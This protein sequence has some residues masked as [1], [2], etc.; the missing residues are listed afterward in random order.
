VLPQ[1]D[2]PQL[3]G[4]SEVNVLEDSG[5]VSV[6]FQVQDVETP[7]SSLQ[8]FVRSLNPV[9][10]P[11]A[12]ISITGNGAS[13]TIRF[14]PATNLFGDVTLEVAAI[15]LDGGAVTNQVLIK[16]A[17]VND[18]PT[19]APLS[20]VEMDRD[21][22]SAPIAIQIGDVE[23][24]AAALNLSAS[25]STPAL[26]P[27]GSFMFGGAGEQ[28]TL[29]L[30]PAPGQYGTA[31]FTLQVTDLDGGIGERSFQVTV[32][33]VIPPAILVAPT[34]QTVTNGASALF[35]VT[36]GGTLP[37]SYQWTLNGTVLANVGP[38]N[39]G[40]YRVTVTNAGGSVASV[41]ALLRVLVAPQIGSV[42]RSGAGID[43]TFPTLENLSYTV[44]FT[45]AAGPLLWTPLTTV[46][47]SGGVLSVYDPAGGLP[48]RLYRVRVN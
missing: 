3:L 1:N 39:A 31:T 34:G 4:L 14:L 36:A 30:V 44:E 45:E 16:I 8:L 27:A 47:G 43:I 24:P 15:D 19:L 18:L 37:I 38:A 12:S 29:V 23:T 2:L 11:D 25:S 10:V 21:T 13:R 9:F 17:S 33:E 7:A 26:F 35:S 40:A 5:E 6:V 20:N 32:R 46:A 41:P 48:A 28:R 22:T 42:A